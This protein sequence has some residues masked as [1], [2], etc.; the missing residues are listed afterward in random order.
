LLAKIPGLQTSVFSMLIQFI[1]RHFPR[2]TK[3]EGILRTGTDYTLF[4]ISFL[5]FVIAVW[6][7]G[8]PQSEETQ[9]GI[10]IFYKIYLAGNGL[11]YISRYFLLFRQ[12]RLTAVAITNLVLGIVLLFEY[13]LSLILGKPYILSSF[14]HLPPFY[15]TLTALLFIF[16]FSRLDLFRFL[17]GLNPPQIFMVSFGSIIL[18]GALFLMMPQATKQHIYFIDAIFTSTSAVCVTGLTAVD[19]ATRFTMLGKAIILALIQIGGLGIMTFT[20]FFAVFFKGTQT[21]REKQI[22]KEWLNDPNLA[23]IKRTLSK[24]VLFMILAEC[25]GIILIYL[26]LDP[27]Y[28][29]KAQ[30]FRFAIF[31]AISAFCN[32]GFS[33]YT[34]N[35]FDHRVRNNTA[36]LYIISSLIVIGGIGF[37]IV[38]NLYDLVKAK[39]RNMFEKWI[40]RFRYV[41]SF[42]LLNINTRLVLVTTFILIIGGAASFFMFEYDHSLK[43]MPLSLK[44]AHSFFS[45]I[46][47]RT[48]GFNS[49]NLSLLSSPAILLTMVL[50]WIGASPVSTGGGIKTTTFAIA[51]LNLS[52]IIKGKDRIEIFRRTVDPNAVG[53][54]FA[55]MFFSLII[56][57]IGAFSIYMIEPR[58]SMLKIAYECFSAYGTVGLSLGITPMLTTAS[59][60]IL[61]LLMFTGRMGTFTLLMVFVSHPKSRPY[62]Y[63]SD[64]IVIT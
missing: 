2:L 14:F 12:H 8:F 17:A 38:L 55:I 16:E 1:T 43:G 34:D 32:A 36:L 3:S 42:G 51:L 10:N 27:Q 45:S 63:P 31:H 64:T 7:T 22:L 24:V 25:I 20:S 57:G 53:R 28:F 29:E 61:V 35:L 26:S 4:F 59:K 48:A 47:P 46:T 62:Q 19:T 54:A 40:K 41:P 5:A 52:K 15:K 44:I 49:V 11:L 23:S 13:S 30:R 21:F 18:T 56:L 33:N 39:L 60:M 50:M 9:R 58:L 6:D 37:P